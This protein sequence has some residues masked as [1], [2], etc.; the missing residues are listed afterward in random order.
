[1]GDRRFSRLAAATGAAFMLVSCGAAST[2]PSPTPYQWTAAVLVHALPKPAF[3]LT[4]QRGQPFDFQRDTAGK[5]TLLYFGY[6]HC[7]DVCP[8]DMAMLA[9]ALRS[10]PPSVRQRVD[11]V[12]VTTDPARDTPPVLAAWLSNFNAG[13]IG[14]TG[15]KAEVD[16]AQRE[17]GVS[18]ASA[19]PAS[20]GSNYG[21][22]HAA[23]IIAYT[24]DN[25]AHVAFFQG[26]SSAAV[27]RD[28]EQLVNVGPPS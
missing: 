28:L 13:F 5:V 4:D 19:E 12:F 21:V 23:E 3:T 6:T 15:D 9:L 7:P 11:V 24:P 14:L 8:Q 10:A 18:L 27:A 2:A 22:D 17:A 25:L 20:P 16:L 1:M 26:M